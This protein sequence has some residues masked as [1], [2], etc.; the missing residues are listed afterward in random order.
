MALAERTAPDGR[1]A[2]ELNRDEARALLDAQAWRY[3]K[4]S[5]DEFQRAWEVGEFD[6]DPDRPEIM[7]VAMLLPLG[8]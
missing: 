1:E 2:Q 4:M 3:L 7:R 8:G 6:D 5:G